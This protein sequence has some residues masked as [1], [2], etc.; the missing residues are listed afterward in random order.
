MFY[1][2]FSALA[3]QQGTTVNAVV[4]EL[5]LA[6][7]SM[8]SWKGGTVPNAATVSKI[9]SYLNVSADYL[10][11]LS[12]NPVGLNIP[13]ELKDVMVGFHRGEFENLTQDEIETLAA[14]AKTLKAQRKL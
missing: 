5:G 11:G 1:E 9:A 12:D 8:T 2:R 3:K 6:K 10:L 14:I 7:G 4:K 13:D